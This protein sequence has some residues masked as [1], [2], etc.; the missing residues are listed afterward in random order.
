MGS[1]GSLASRRAAALR[2]AAVLALT[3]TAEGHGALSF[4][5]PRNAIDG[6]R[7]ASEPNRRRRGPGSGTR[8]GAAA[9]STPRR[10][11]GDVAAAT[12]RPDAVANRRAA[13]AAGALPAWT[14]WAYPCDATHQGENCSI[15]FCEDGDAACQGSCPITARSGVAGEL[16]ASNGQA[17]YW[18]SNGCTGGRG[19]NQRGQRRRLGDES[20]PRRGRDVDIPWRRVAAPPATWIFRGDESRPRLRRGH[21][22]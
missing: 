21:S 14:E 4:P 20:R 13:A 11:R 18:F 2:A 16:A 9:R 6:A 3:G 12:L 5:T 7:P 10:G 15:T 19:G 1:R 8:G 17:C 22:V